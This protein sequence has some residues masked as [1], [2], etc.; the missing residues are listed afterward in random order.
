MATVFITGASRA[1]RSSKAALNSA[2]RTF[3]FDHPEVIAAMVSP[4]RVRTDMNPEA[5]GA[6]ETS[7]ASLRKIIANLAQADSGGFFRVDGRPAPW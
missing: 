1:Y 7:V 2:W 5:P 4:G 3:A 6:T